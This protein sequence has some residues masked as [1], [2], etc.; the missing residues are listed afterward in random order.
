M[1]LRDYFFAESAPI[2]ASDLGRIAAEGAPGVGL[3]IVLGVAGVVLGDYVKHIDALV[4]SVTFGMLVRTAI[5]KNERVLLRVRPG[6]VLAQMLFIPIGIILYGKNLELRAV[7]STHPLVIAQT[8]LVATLTMVA[9][10]ALGKL[11]WFKLR[12]RM[13]YLLGFGSAV[14]GASAIAITSPV[15]EC[16]PDETATALVTNTLAVLLA[17]WLMTAIFRATT[18]PMTYATMAGELMHQTGI[19]KMALADAAKSVQEFGLAVKSLRV[20]SLVVFI[21]IVSYLLRRRFFLPWYLIVF[22]AV[23]AYFSYGAVPAQAAKV[24]GYVH[25]IAF[26]TALASIGLASN[27]RN[28]VKRIVKPLVLVLVVFGIDLG[29]F[30]VTKGFFLG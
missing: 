10:V 18:P 2:K 27:L 30:L 22:V 7:T 1:S 9:M 21:P 25:N 16:E 14:C 5:A 24:V 11:P 13:L 6:I 28:V 12:D 17:L 15:A 23:G 20:A 19:V 8:A 29:F 3:A 4:A 26:A